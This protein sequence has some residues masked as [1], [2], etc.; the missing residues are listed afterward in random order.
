MGLFDFI[1]NQFIEVIEWTDNGTT[2][3]VYRFPV[4]G[5][6]IKMGAQ[7]TVRESQ[8][9]IFVNEGQIADVFNA[10]RYTL[11]TQNMPV[12][13]KLKSWQYGFNSP[14]KAEVYFI[15]TKQFTDQKWGT[16]NPIM[17]RDRD[18]GMLRLRGFGIFSFKVEDPIVFLKEV[19]GTN[20]KY[21]VS[22]ISGQLKRVIISVLSDILAESQI[23]A[24]D[25]AMYYNE[26]SEKAKEDLQKHFIKLG[27]KVEAF[28]IE[29]IS[30]PKEVEQVLDKKTSMGLLGDMQQYTQYQAA[31]A[32]RDAAKN[33]ANGFA[34]AGVGL[35]AGA[36]IGQMMAGALNNQ[37]PVKH[38]PMNQQTEKQKA[39]PN[40][41][42]QNPVENKFCFSC[43]TKIEEEKYNCIACK[44][45]I[46]KDTKFC[47]ECGTKQIKEVI[48]P[49]CNA[50]L[51]PNTKFCPE[52][53]N[54]L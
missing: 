7:L 34:S 14:F 50:K 30:L 35:G 37:Q 33:E 44:A 51:K 10:G 49:K 8:V 16:T 25:L 27:F 13:T 11:S 47:P 52:C 46:N 40:C 21:D 48:C 41:K 4:E 1:K 28:Y 6:E 12:L 42:A 53:G 3:M 15:N 19:F 36:G 23:P 5:K 38:Q 20:A 17:M 39:C 45:E 2:T 31:E 32:M 26:L 18:F 29:N 9:A 43:G 54:K 24:I 22:S